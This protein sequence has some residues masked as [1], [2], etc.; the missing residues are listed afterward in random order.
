MP[1][2]KGAVSASRFRVSGKT[3]KDVRGWLTKA[4][5]RKGFEPIDPKG[6]D[7][8]ASGFVELENDRAT[9][10]PPGALFEGEH[11]LFAWRVETI[12][13][14]Q[15]ALR[16]KLSEWAA[17]FESKNGRAPGRAQKAEQ[18]LLIRKG[19]RARTDPTVKVFDVSYA[20]DSQELLV[21]ATSATIVEEV[22]SALEESLEVRLVPCVPA[23]LLDGDEVDSLMPTPELFGE[24]LSQ[25]AKT[26]NQ[27][28]A[29]A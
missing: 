29:V 18:K 9:E 11:A 23:A 20:L 4:L 2:R 1:I 16:T 26:A 14:P 25:L 8:R 13:I 27:P 17:A 28:K 6:D 24:E 12:R 3:P 15:A 22:Q 19:L 10:F 7:E 5:K 21:W